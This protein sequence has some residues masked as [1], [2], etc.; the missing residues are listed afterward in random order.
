MENKKY[1]DENFDLKT[2]KK[3]GFIKN[4]KDYDAIEKRI[5]E[6]FGLSNIYE[7]STILHNKEIKVKNIFSEN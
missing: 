2:L 4:I 1:I 5:C 7:Y 6:W 3:V